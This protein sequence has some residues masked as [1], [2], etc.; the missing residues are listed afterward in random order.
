MNDCVEWVTY[1][2]SSG[3]KGTLKALVAADQAVSAVSF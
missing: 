3:L 2:M 1:G